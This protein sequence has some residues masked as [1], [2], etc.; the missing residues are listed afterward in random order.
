VFHVELR[1]FPHV[2]RVFNLEA[3]EL[4]ARIV[5]PWVRGAAVELQDRRWTSDRARLT[6]YEGPEVPAEERGLGRGWSTVTRDGEN[7]TARMIEAAAGLVPRASELKRDLVASIGPLALS[8]AVALAGPRG[9]P[10]ERLAAAEQAVWELLHEGRVSLLKA[11]V[12]VSASDWGPLLL[13]WETWSD[14]AIQL[15]VSGS[16][17]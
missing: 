15:L 17:P 6:I 10:S 3:D 4:H 1:R 9:R 5:V 8:E 16:A 2:A 12:E 7:V 11:G 14:P 13:S